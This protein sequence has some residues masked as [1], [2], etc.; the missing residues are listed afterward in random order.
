MGRRSRKKATETHHS[1]HDRS[2]PYLRTLQ[3]RHQPDAALA[4]GVHEALGTNKSLENPPGLLLEEPDPASSRNSEQLRALLSEFNDA[5]DQFP[6]PPAADSTLARKSREL[7]RILLSYDGFTQWETLV[8]NILADF[9]C[10]FPFNVFCITVAKEN[11]LS[12]YI[13]Y[14]GLYSKTARET[15]RRRLAKQMLAALHLP[16]DTLLDIEE[17]PL[18]RKELPESFCNNTQTIIAP[19]PGQIDNLAAAYVGKRSLRPREQAVIRSMLSII[20]TVVSGGSSKMAARTITDI[21]LHA[22]RDQLTGLYNRRYFN[23][24]LKHEIGRSCRQQHELSLLLLDVDNFKRVTYFYGHP[25]RD[26]V[27]CVIARIVEQQL[28]KGDLAARLGDDQFAIILR[29][30]GGEEAMAVAEKLGKALREKRFTSQDN[31]HFHLTVSIG[32][33]VYPFDVGAEFSLRAVTDTASH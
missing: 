16:D 28:R 4:H 31:E 8:S 3:L 25:V 15:I 17:Y 12:L 19:V 33:V 23:S 20:A 24:T 22:S 7:E 32:M 29:E 27:L 18:D 5:L 11:A 6:E 13:F 14:P 26:E 21:E 9:H 30:T 1:S 2:P 10:V